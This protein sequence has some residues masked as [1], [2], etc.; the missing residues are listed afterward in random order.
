MK[1]NLAILLTSL[2]CF[3]LSVLVCAADAIQQNEK[4][5][6]TF[7]TEDGVLVRVFSSKSVEIEEQADALIIDGKVYPY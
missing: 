4:T 6:T 3:L 1:K 7:V 5:V 2:M